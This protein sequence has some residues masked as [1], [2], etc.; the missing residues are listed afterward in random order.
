MKKRNLQK[1]SCLR[2]QHTL[3]IDQ[4]DPFKIEATTTIQ[5]EKTKTGSREKSLHLQLELEYAITL[6]KILVFIIISQYN[7]ISYSIYFVHSRI[8]SFQQI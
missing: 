7:L 4:C 8:F 1:N 6:E 5:K 3:V 2:R